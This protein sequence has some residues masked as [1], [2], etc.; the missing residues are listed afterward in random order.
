[1]FNELLESW[2]AE[3]RSAYLYEILAVKEQG[4]YREALFRRLGQEAEN[5]AVI[6]EQ[7]I[8]ALGRKIPESLP[9]DVR[10]RIVT[11][12]IR[13]LSP[14]S[15]L[16]VLAAMKIRGLSIYTSSL[17]THPLPTSVEQ[18]GKRHQKRGSGGNLRAAIFGI[19]DGLVS[20]AALICGISG[21]TSS[22]PHMVV[23]AGVAGLL[24]G[25][26]SM[27]AGEYV[28]VLSQREMFEYQIGLEAEELKL[29]PEEEA[30]ELA[31][32]F[33]ARGMEQDEAKKFADRLIQDPVRALDTLAR[34]ELG[35][36]PNELGSA[37]QAALFSFLFFSV[38][39][40]VPLV[41]FLMKSNNSPF[42]W[43]IGLTGAALFIIGASI[44]LFTGKNAL[45]GAFR[46]LA[47]GSA[48]GALTYWI[49][50]WL[51]A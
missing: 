28:S 29:Y 41:P 13:A 24:A 31:L 20:N 1:M 51:G 47:I 26:F 11:A 14:K 5:Q 33:H 10:T 39:A 8:S 35:L 4:T 30:M 48:A 42:E 45:L 3:K 9:I 34:E 37:P 44:S 18:I 16:V 12:L 7:K 40:L 25:A 27:A 32:I 2:L 19:N 15:I 49:G 43:A 23:Y 36:D 17:P 38:G 50:H 22:E 6:W 21:A 46:M